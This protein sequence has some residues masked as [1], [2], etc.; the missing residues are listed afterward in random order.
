MLIKQVTIDGIDYTRCAIYPLK[1]KNTLDESLDQSTL[2]LGFTTRELPFGRLSE[3]T[4][5]IEDSVGEIKQIDRLVASD[6][7]DEV[8]VCGQKKWTHTLILIE[9]TKS[10][11]RDFVDTKTITNALDA[12]RKFKYVSAPVVGSVWTYLY[13]FKGRAVQ[14]LDFD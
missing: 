7:V 9:L 3:V 8:I 4:I 11:E 2:T 13:S 12:G 14:R 10:L 5:D 1:N 6:R